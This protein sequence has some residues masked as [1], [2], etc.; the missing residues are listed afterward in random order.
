MS[1]LS[2]DQY[3]P[4]NRK[5]SKR[6]ANCD[7]QAFDASESPSTESQ[8]PRARAQLIQVQHIRDPDLTAIGAS[9]EHVQIVL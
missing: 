3:P 1:R 8:D 7:S 6:S 5:I 4:T 9:G 2:I